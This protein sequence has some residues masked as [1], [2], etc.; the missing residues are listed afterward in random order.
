MITLEKI[1]EAIVNLFHEPVIMKEVI[2]QDPAY[3]YNRVQW[4]QII[5]QNLW[6][7]GISYN[8]NQYTKLIHDSMTH[9]NKKGSIINGQ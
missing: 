9:Y 3:Q 5:M 6:M 7:D 1:D 4:M 2:Q 8:H